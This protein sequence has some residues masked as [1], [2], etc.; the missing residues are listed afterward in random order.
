M[1]PRAIQKL[2]L[3]IATLSET[4]AQAS[5][6]LEAGGAA[7]NDE[8]FMHAGTLGSPLSLVLIS[9]NGLGIG[10]ACAE[11]QAPHKHVK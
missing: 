10:F 11:G 5:C 7:S 1:R 9:N 2:Y 6:Q 4:V 3:R 8:D